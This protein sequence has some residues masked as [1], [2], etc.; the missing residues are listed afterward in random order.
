MYKNHAQS[1][2]AKQALFPPPPT[3]DRLRGAR[4][5]VTSQKPISEGWRFD[6]N[7]INGQHL[8]QGLINFS[9]GEYSSSAD[10]VYI[11][12][13]RV[14][15]VSGRPAEAAVAA[16]HR[17]FPINGTSSEAAGVFAYTLPSTTIMY[18]KGS[19]LEAVADAVCYHVFAVRR[20]YGVEISFE[21][22]IPNR[23]QLL[24][25]S[26]FLNEKKT[27]E[28]NNA[29]TLEVQRLLYAKTQGDNPQPCDGS[30]DAYSSYL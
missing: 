12:T 2:P 30:V 13:S 28:A 17:A 26:S 1:P 3:P 7:D 6:Y 14:I 25:L 16:E 8:I 27:E 18:G 29:V 11:V 9:H 21:T 20:F 19:L 5:F 22:F 10:P 24:R 23:I 15:R 4:P